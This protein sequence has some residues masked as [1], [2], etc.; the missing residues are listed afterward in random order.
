[1]TEADQLST[2]RN[3]LRTWVARHPLLA[4][5][6]L[7][8]ILSCFW[9]LNDRIDLGMVNG[10]G[11]IGSISPALAAMI[12]AAILKP[13]P[14][15]IQPGKR[16]RLFGIIGIL[17]LA[18]MAVVRFWNSAG[19]V[20][21]S[22]LP[23]LPDAYPSFMAFPVDVLAAAV[24]AFILS[25]VLSPRQGVRDLLHS[26]DP[27]ETP[28]RWY[29]WA[30]A[31][32][33]LSIRLHP[34][35]CRI[36]FNRHT[37]TG[38]FG[39]RSMVFYVTGHPHHVHLFPVRRRRT[40]GTW[41]ARFCTAFAA[42]AFQPPG[43]QFDPVCHLDILAFTHIVD[44][45]CAKRPVA[46]GHLSSDGYRP[47]CDPVHGIIQPD[48]RQPA[49]RHPAAHFHQ[50]HR[51]IPAGILPCHRPLDSAHPGHR[52]LDVALP[53]DV[54]AASAGKRIR[55]CNQSHFQQI[56][57]G[58]IPC[59]DRGDGNNIPLRLSPGQSPRAGKAKWVRAGRKLR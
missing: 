38:A 1:M 18:V 35:Q 8:Y 46:A 12:V 43:L 24:V 27:R 10:F 19:L 36:L 22:S 41:L 2:G 44:S 57:R 15:G 3:T 30:I 47:V 7:A 56:S 39:V 48:S 9:L 59:M 29:W 31:A 25:G 37:A 33:N 54:L 21:V 32:G 11:V 42:E 53:A 14:S 52:R 6:I 34:R 49:N 23:A 40:R 58:R 17:V 50:H 4:F 55:C 20:T 16:W 28:V 13:E 51:D 26:L 45:H 5:I